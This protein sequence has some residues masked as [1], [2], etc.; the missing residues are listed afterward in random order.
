MRRGRT[1][2]A[3]LDVHRLIEEVLHLVAGVSLRRSSAARKQRKRFE[4]G[5]ARAANRN[6]GDHLA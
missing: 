2:P 4:S 5:I 6:A 1:E 3:A